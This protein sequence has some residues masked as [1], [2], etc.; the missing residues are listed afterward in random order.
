MNQARLGITRKYRALPQKNIW[1]DTALF[2]SY[3]QVMR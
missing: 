2:Y 3:Q 1:H